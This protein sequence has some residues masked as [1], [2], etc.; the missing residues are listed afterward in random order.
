MA[1]LGVRKPP[2]FPPTFTGT[3]ESVK[4]DTQVMLDDARAVVEK[5]VKEIEPEKATFQNVMVPQLDHEN[6]MGL[7]NRVLGF[8]SSVST[9]LDL[10]NASSEAE[11]SMEEYSIE[12]SMRDDMF[13]IIKAIWEKELKN[14]T[15][16]DEDYRILEK[17]YRAYL[18]MGLGIP[19]GP[20]RDRFKEI[21]MRLSQISIA[22]QKNLNEETNCLWFTRDEL[23]GYP[24][25]LLATLKVG[26]AEEDGEE[27]VGKYRLTFKYPEM[28]PALKYVKN[29]ET[30]RKVFVSNE[31]KVPDNVALFKEAIV[32]RDEAARLLGYPNHAVFRLED[33]MAKTADRVNKFLADLHKR[34]APGAEAELAKLKQLKAEDLKSRGLEDQDDGHYYL[35]DHRFY[36]R[37][38]IEREFSIDQEAISEYF[39]IQ[40]TIRSM[41]EIFEQLFGLQFVELKTKEERDAVAESGNGDDVVWHEDVN[42]FTVWD[43]EG[44]GGGFVGYF[45]LDLFPRDG[46]Y[47]HAANFNLQPGY[48]DVQTGKRH[49]PATALVCNFSK[50]TAKKPSLL[51]HEEVVTLFHELGHGIHDLVARTRYSRFHGTDVV[52]DFVEAPSQ[53]LEN[54]CWTPSQ[55]R[56]LSHH[57]S[58]LSEEYAKE[59]EESQKD[60]TEDPQSLKKPDLHIPDALIEKLIA[61]K[62]VNGALFNLRQLHFGMFDM[63]IHQ[64]KNHEEIEKLV[65]SALYNALRRDISHLDGMDVFDG[66]S[67]D[68]ADGQATF[69]H[70]VPSGFW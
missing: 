21:K 65:P 66:S 32:L 15:L 41:L 55:L 20:K 61:T 58:H 35:W 38:Q 17:D 24:E 6:K 52:R 68:W 40:T 43:D 51:K 5:M 14:R 63:T 37:L 13:Q 1:S 7:T 49:Y 22:F 54:W 8:Y 47:S 60:K 16:D 64:G 48:I 67:D 45:Y 10:R 29:S 25:D 56:S 3:P 19:A 27:N 44:E 70:L 9:D 59:W 4:R 2:Q 57:Y 42:M 18:R 39:P 62:H 23:D 11:Q 33:K 50:P 34:L 53:M 30:R 69:G 12:I 26:N 31:K 46:K 36:N 28:F